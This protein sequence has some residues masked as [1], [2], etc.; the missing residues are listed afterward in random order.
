MRHFS[1]LSVGLKTGYKLY[2]LNNLEQLEP[3]FEKGQLPH[4]QIKIKVQV[5]QFYLFLKKEE[6]CAL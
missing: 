1:S 6:K 3:S 4:R 2:A 5:L